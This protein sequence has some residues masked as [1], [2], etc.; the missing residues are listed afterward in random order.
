MKHIIRIMSW[1]FDKEERW[2]NDMSA[3]GL[4]L[5][6]YS[7]CRY[8]FVDAPLNEYTY[9]IELL[10]YPPYHSES[11]EYIRF[12]NESGVEYITSN[13]RWIYLRKKTSDGKFD[14]YS[15]IHSKIKH[16]QRILKFWI[17][18]MMLDFAF[19]VFNIIIGLKNL[20]KSESWGLFPHSNLIAGIL[21][22]LFGI[23]L[24]R[25][26]LRLIKKINILQQERTVRE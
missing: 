3:K 23:Y 20:S 4:A 14:I 21:V 10:K 18:S 24:L 17:S 15:D 22:I 11:E 9:R 6:Y 19:G 2:L 25:L 7:W 13:K 1:D 16:Y 12:L 26:C 5:K 8:V